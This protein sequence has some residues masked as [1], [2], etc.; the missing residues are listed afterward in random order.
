M[1]VNLEVLEQS[2]ENVLPQTPAKRDLRKLNKVF[3]EQYS[4]RTSLAQEQKHHELRVA[5]YGKESLTIWL[6][7]IK[8][9]EQNFPAGHKDYVGLLERCTS[10]LVESEKYKNS[11]KYLRVWMK[12]VRL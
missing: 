9:M 12:L 6:D 8:W 10:A 2:K 3:S 1:E 11:K 4:Q 7:Y 5:K